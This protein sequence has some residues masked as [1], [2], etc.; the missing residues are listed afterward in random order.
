MPRLPLVAIITTAHAITAPVD[1][2]N[3]LAGSFTRG[4]VFS[5]GN[6]LPLVGRPWGFNHWALQ[7]NDGR[8]AWWFNGND[9][10][11]KWIRCTHQPSPWIGDYGW[12]MVGPQM[13]GFASSPTGFFEPRAATVLPHVLDF[14]TAPDG[15]RVELS[16][17]MHGASLRVTFPAT[18][19]LEK[20]ICVKLGGGGNDGYE[21]SNGGVDARTNRHSGAVASNFA[22][23]LRVESKTQAQ[24]EGRGRDCFCFSYD[25]GATTV[26]VHLATSFIGKVLMRR[27]SRRRGGER[28]RIAH[29][30]AID[31]TSHAGPS[32]EESAGRAQAPRRRAT[33]RRGRVELSVIK[34]VRRLYGTIGQDRTGPPGV[35]Y[36]SIPSLELS[37]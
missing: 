26:E 12:F 28:Y 32:L 18:A 7:T 30:H 3:L 20:R 13:G 27:P 4:D 24:F 23:H 10:E 36:W 21:Q 11:F 17:T 9:H 37:T 6:T 25:R 8:S 16:P 1:Y 15:M 29:A 19:R 35:L 5:T 2:V 22:H 14:R 31:A 33:G 34:G